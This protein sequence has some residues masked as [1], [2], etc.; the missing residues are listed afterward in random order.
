MPLGATH[1]VDALQAGVRDYSKIRILAVDRIPLPE[2]EELAGA[3]RYSHIIT[4]ASRGVAIGHG[5]IVR[6]DSWNDRELLIH[7]FVHVAQCE[8]SGSLEEY[9]RAYLSDRR[10]CAKFTVG[11]FE[12]EA[13]GRA[14]E[15]CTAG[16]AAV[17]IAS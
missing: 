7:Q 5:I 11:W 15:I 6:A 10:D 2:D 1:I 14:R 8:R 9:I 13:R 16:E 3:A 4:D 17:A 12:Q